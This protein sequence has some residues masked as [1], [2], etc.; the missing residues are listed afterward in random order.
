MFGFEE[1]TIAEINQAFDSGLLTSEQLVQ[2]YLDR[3]AAFDQQG[4]A[5]NS[6]ITLNPNALGRAIALDQERQQQGPRGPLHGIPIVIK[7]NIDTADLPTT[8]GAFV[9][10][11][12]LPPD[13]A[14]VVQ[15]LREAGAIILGKTNLDEFARNVQGVS[16]LG[17]QTLNPYDFAR[18]PGG[19]S[20]GTAVAITANFAVLGLGTETGVSIR[21]PVANNSLVGI[22]PTEGLVSRDGT[23]PISFT[24][25]RV[26]PIARTVEDAAIALDI[27]AGFDDSDPITAESTGNIPAAGYTS[28]LSDQALEGARI[29]VFRDLFRT[30]E[31]HAESLAIIEQAIDD[32]AAEGAVIIDD[33]SLGI[34]LFS[35]LDNA[36]LNLFETEF[37]VNNYLDSL[38]SGAPV[39]NLQE[40]LDDGRLLPRTSLI[41]GFSQGLSSSF[42]ENPDYLERLSQREFLQEATADLLEEFDLDALVYPMKTLPAPFLGKLSPNSDN[43]F[44]S[45]T[46]LP[47]IVVPA[48]VTSAGL[49][50]GLEFS[51]EPFSEALLLGFA[52]DYEQSTQQRVAPA[53][54]PF[55]TTTD[56]MQVSLSTSTTFDG[57]L[58]ALVE[59][60][61]TTITFRFDLDEPAPAGGLTLFVDAD[62]EQMLNRLDLPEFAFN[63]TTENIDFE[64]LVTNRDSSGFVATINEGATFGTATL[65]IFNNPEPDTFLPDTFDGLV[66]ATFS[67]QTEDQ[68]DRDVEGPLPTLSDYTIDAAAA[69]SVVLFADDATQLPTAPPLTGPS[70]PQVSLFTGPSY[71][72][73]DEGTVS[74]HAFNVT[75]GVI[76]EGGL[77][78]SVDAPNLSEFDLDGISVEGGEVVAVRDGGF[79]L[80]MT[81]YTTL[82]NLPIAN[83]GETE[84]GETASFML[85][86]GDGYEIISD[87]SGGSFNLVDTR[88][89]IPR[90]VINEPNNDIANATETQISPENPTFFGTDS[91]YFD[92]GNRYLNEDGTYTYIDYSED[93]D[94]YKVDLKAGDTI[95]IETFDFDTNVDE[96]G[97]GFA[98]NAFVYDAEGNQLQD[99]INTGFDPAAAPD[100]LFGGIGPF[101]PNETDSYDEF[102]A[103]A[104][105]SYF[106]AVGDDGQVQNFW[107]EVAPF[108]DPNVPGSGQGNRAIFGDYSIEINLLTEDNPR[109]TGTPTPPDSNPDVV[110][111]PMLSLSANP[112]TTDGDGNFTNTVVE[113][114]DVGGVSSVTFTIQADGE[115]PEGGLEFV[116]NSDANLFDYVSYL[117]QSA[118]PSTIG[119]QSLGAYYNAEGIPTGIRLRIEEPLMTVTYEAA[120]NQPW[121]PTFYGNIVGRYEPLET[122]GPETVNFFLQPGEGYTVSA[123]AGATD[124]TY[125]DS[126]ADVPPPTTGGDTVPEVSITASET[127]LIETEQTE[128]T[129]TLNLSEAP[130]PEGLT[131][132]VDSEDDTTVGSPLSQFSVLEAEVT[133]GNFPIPNG[134]S[135]GFFFTVTEQTA[136]ITLS[137]F[138]ELTVRNID[139][140]TVQEGIVG[141]NFALQ[142]LEGYT[143]DPEASEINFTIADNVDSGIQVSLI[144]EPEAL[145]ESEGTVSVH[146][147]S[148]STP[149]PAE[150]LTVSVATSALGEFNLDA[151][152]VAGG[153]I[154]A[155]RDDGF[156]LTITEQTAT[157]SLPVLSDGVAE[158]SETAS[159]ALVESDDYELNAAFNEATFTLADTLDQAT[160][161]EESE[162]FGDEISNSTIPE[163]NAL[164]LS[165]D[166][167][168]VSI[169]G[170]IGES[171]SDLPEDVDFFSFNL[172]A[173]QTVGLDIDTEKILPNTIN[174]RQVVY[175]ALADI[176]QKPDTELRLFDADG[177][178]LATNRDGAAPGE[179]FSRDPYLEFT[180]ETAG[181]YYV[182]VS[183]LGNRN[184]D[185]FVSRT[186]SG[187]TFP[188]VGINN[189]FYDL[190]A[191]LIEGDITP[192][193]N[194]AT[195]GDDTLVGTAGDDTIAGDLG[196]DIM[197]GGAGDDVLRG[198]LNSRSPQ[199]DVAGGNDIIFG[200][201]G[202]DRIGGKAGN[203]ILSGDA[204]DDFIWGDDGD[205]IIMGVTGNDTLVGDNFSDGSGSDLFVFGNGDGT[206][207]IVDFEVGI[208]RIGLVEGELTF[209]EL[210]VTQDGRNTLLGVAD[211]GEVLAIMQNVQASALTKSSFELVPDISNP[212]EAM[213]IA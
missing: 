108:Y 64:S 187:W 182:G 91:V 127:T 87:Y 204:G 166:N 128:T 205:D 122:D 168:S 210:T 111:P 126:V 142:P 136:T 63:P 98:I 47:G 195:P 45:I 72:I 213:A 88:L 62:V 8:A 147:F 110:N 125:Y 164:S 76:P 114:V 73:E 95:T 89:D 33:V 148:L 174:F 77:V 1:A 158:G 144:G 24:L 123:E 160:V 74:A 131:I 161:A 112:T 69:T 56:S 193:D 189:G 200:G 150:G 115:V 208:D 30:G 153:S 104:D 51:G 113:H 159:F 185:P 54:V 152:E 6:I 194:I 186:G 17:G 103:P 192:P 132:F 151:I 94:V 55:F 59:T 15:E 106:I 155:V 117:G 43:P 105:G 31:P 35:L 61:G 9:L 71:L 65:N 21:N 145:I 209:A 183:Q 44:S 202:D 130:P 12:F 11:D 167:P 97:V 20:G 80:R 58:N 181:T 146:T 211:S 101:D 79:D 96:F 28:L 18:A 86:P 184:Y 60:Q 99:Y 197:T 50:V 27:I 177:N 100:K 42:E 16:A 154:A 92:I 141:L 90:G 40:I 119:G 165:V 52:Y 135:S 163:A 83:D 68:V 53:S 85:A 176:L 175:P 26:G 14:F 49:P 207:T 206:D 107:D 149:P 34:D 196:N 36:R 39:Q 48:G 5:L 188:E 22:A 109:K 84:T 179:E 4:P 124:V 82:V 93:V 201:D 66:E 140:L 67:L 121:F 102:T 203:D 120:N 32:L 19:S 25:D 38:G 172:D 173:G 118:L 70:L 41:F 3:I 180:A 10:E 23:V 162:L 157:I 116:L 7:D 75:D 137:V 29:G 143:I 199:D 134:D 78:V 46:G 156:D 178:E 2:L 169:S 138:D 13:D 129:I 81:E 170:L 133:G 212:Q 57:D 171:F 139:P 37:A 198:D 191:T 190:T